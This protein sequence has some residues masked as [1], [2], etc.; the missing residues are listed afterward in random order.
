MKINFALICFKQIDDLNAD[1]K[2][3]CLYQTQPSALDIEHLKQELATEP[4][5]NMIG[6]EDYEI[7]LIARPDDEETFVRLGIPAEADG[8]ADESQDLVN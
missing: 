1:V 6:D 4:E 8:L 3:I 5:F 2:H 7:T